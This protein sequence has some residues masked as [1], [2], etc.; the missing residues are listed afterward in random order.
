MD[1]QSCRA[2][3]PPPHCS[4]KDGGEGSTGEEERVERHG[5]IT[6]K[7]GAEDCEEARMTTEGGS[8]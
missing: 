6:P 3:S 7:G 2:D 4:N 8:S 1:R 5:E